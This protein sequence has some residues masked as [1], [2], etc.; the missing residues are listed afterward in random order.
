MKKTQWMSAAE[1]M[2][3]LA[4][5]PQFRSQQEGQ[6]NARKQKEER[7]RV[8][9]APLMAELN[10]SEIEAHTL[11]DL[12]SY[13]PLPPKITETL[14]RYLPVIDDEVLQE[15]V[16]RTLG[17]S[18]EKF[19]GLELVKLFESSR[20]ENLR[21]AI[22]NTIAEAQPTGITGWVTTAAG[23]S[24]YGR[25]REMLVL[26]VARLAPAHVAR[27]ILAAL[28]DEL[29][30]HVSIA[31]IEFGDERELHLLQEKRLNFKGWK[32]KEIDRAIARIQRNL[33]RRSNTS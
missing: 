23:N 20:S 18:K 32:K 2:A 9:L 15:Q 31:L 14:L 5:D 26:A 29:P 3:R 10:S 33:S 11:E 1:L 22:A 27:E 28:F 12:K 24:S 21:W 17:A 6:E 19:N 16:V 4:A 25:A 13:A 30:G 8:L 7:N